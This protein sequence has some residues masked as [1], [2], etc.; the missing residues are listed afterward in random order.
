MP[1]QR[2]PQERDI[3]LTEQGATNLL[4]YLEAVRRVADRLLS[5]GYTIV[6][7]VLQPPPPDHR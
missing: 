2:D 5:E 3:A 7:G 6:D 1:E 4:G